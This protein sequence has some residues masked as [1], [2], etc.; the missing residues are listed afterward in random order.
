M[1]KKLVCLVL[2]GIM[3]IGALA[4]CGDNGT[5]Q[6]A[7]KVPGGTPSS[8]DITTTLSAEELR[9]IRERIDTLKEAAPNGFDGAAF[10]VVGVEDAAF[11]PT[12]EEIIGDKESDAIY[13]RNMAVNDDFNVK[14]TAV[15]CEDPHVV[16]DNVKN[17]VTAGTN[18]YHLVNGGVVSNG[19]DLFNNQYINPVDVYP[20]INL[21][22]RWWQNSLEEYYA[23]GNRVFFLAGDL[24]PSYF[25]TPFCVLFSKQLMED[26]D[27]N[28]NLYD[29]VKNK[30]WTVDKMFDLAQAI[31]GGGDVYRYGNHATS[32]GV[33]LYFGAGNV[34]TT[35]D[36]EHMPV[37]VESFSNEAYDLATK[38]SAQTGDP[39]YS[40]NLAFDDIRS[41]YEKADEECHRLFANDKIL[42]M[43]DTGGGISD[44]R[45]LDTNG[46]G[47]LPIPM[48]SADQK[49][50]ISYSVS[51]FSAVF[52]PRNNQDTKMMGVVVEA[53][54]A[55]GYQYIRPAFYD[56]RLKSKS[57]YDMESK[58]MLDIIYS[59]EI[60]DL[61]DL[62]GGGSYD[63]GNGEAHKL[64]DEAMWVN[65]EG[66]MGKY[67]ALVQMTKNQVKQ[68]KKTAA[69]Y[70]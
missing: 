51:G 42:F 26:Y 4:S 15:K 44:L 54:G 22:G 43:V 33:A 39:S 8:D 60:Y 56:Q 37:F 7:A 21:D 35:F 9:D 31:P 2:C 55:Y 17:D 3:L 45:K 57:S 49:D 70:N 46:F 36:G 65:S 29:L 47:I 62:Y 32:A 38:I 27:I 41:A 50:Y 69:K 19:Q 66:V 23:I 67:S 14:I 61:Y 68:F 6:T 34:M 25:N 24:S 30:E 28:V 59:T 18:Q 48:G 52:L 58:E 53:M 20:D 13:K 10:N 16:T 40:F 63:T 64:I 12:E 5:A 1:V 11:F